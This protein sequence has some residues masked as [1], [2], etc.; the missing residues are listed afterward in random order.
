MLRGKDRFIYERALDLLR[1]TGLPLDMAIAEFVE[2]KNRLN[3]ACTLRE[4]VETTRNLHAKPVSTVTVQQ[5]VDEFVK[6]KDSEGL[7]HLYRRDL[8][9][10]L[11]RF[12]IMELRHLRY[13]VAV[14]E[15]QNVSFSMSFLSSLCSSTIL[16]MRSR[17]LSEQFHLSLP[18][19]LLCPF[20]CLP[21]PLAS[22]RYRQLLA[23]VGAQPSMSLNGNCYD[24]AAME[25]FWSSL[26]RELIHR[27]RFVTRAAARAAV[28]DWT[29]LITT[30]SG[31]QRSRLS[32]PVDFEK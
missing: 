16:M 11:A 20:V 21:F 23:G 26:K 22:G 27:V 2:A 9:T 17:C 30:G 12:G 3:G 13:F 14:A 25:S 1:P 15:E 18:L 8:R 31:P 28:F 32:I 7:S 24:N 29:N 5:V 19:P 10:R 6:V 4:A